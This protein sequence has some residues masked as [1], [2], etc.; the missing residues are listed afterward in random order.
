MKVIALFF[1]LILYPICCMANPDDNTQKLLKV[2]NFKTFQAEFNQ[3]V[4]NKEGV[5]LQIAEGRLAIKKP[6]KLLW[7][8]IKPNQQIIVADGQKL[9]IYDK[10]L[11]QVIVYQQQKTLGQTPALILSGHETEFTK[12][13]SIASESQRNQLEQQYKLMPKAQ[14]ENFRS[15]FLMTQASQLKGMKLIDKLENE[16]SIIFNNVKINLP[17]KDDYF[18]FVPPAGSDIIDKS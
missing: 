1:L 16:S 2:L 11:E 13:F 17:I 6:G 9:W 10:D 3:T 14:S 8:V 18:H 12:T 4:K 5:V 15:I 7:R